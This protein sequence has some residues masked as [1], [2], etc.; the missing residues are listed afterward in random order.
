MEVIIII[1]TI[2]KKAEILE[3]DERRK[4]R[5]RINFWRK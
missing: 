5:N 3:N 1:K 2:N 4:K